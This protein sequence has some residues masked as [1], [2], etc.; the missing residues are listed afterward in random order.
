LNS[1]KYFLASEVIYF[2]FLRNTGRIERIMMLYLSA[3]GST[4]VF[5][6]TQLK[7]NKNILY[8]SATPIQPN[9]IKE[10]W[11]KKEKK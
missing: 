10:A 2:I 3:V 4:G 7:P 6:N 11:F 9:R 5:S 8:K 1:I